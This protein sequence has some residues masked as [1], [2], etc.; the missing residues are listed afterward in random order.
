[1]THKDYATVDENGH[2]ILPPELAAAWGLTPGSRLAVEADGQAVQMRP[3][4]TSLRRVYV[5][6][7]NGCN[8]NCATCMRNVW[9][10]ETGCMSWGTFERILAGIH[11]LQPAPEIFFG[12]YGEPLSH[13]DC[14]EMV[15]RAKALGLQ[16]SLITNGILLTKEVSTRLVDV[17]LDMLWVSLDGASPQSYRDVRLGNA[18]PGI[19]KNLKT[20]RELQ[21][22][23]FE[24]F[25]WAS[26]PRLG[27][28]FVAM[29]RN[30]ADLLNVIRLGKNLGATQFSIS[31]VLAHNEALCEESLYL[32]TIDVPGLL[33]RESWKSQVELPQIDIN[34]ATSD[35]LIELL[36]GDHRLSLF[37]RPINGN[38][39]RCPFVERGSLVVRW[40][41]KVSPCLPLLYTHT[42]YLGE[43]Q[44]TSRE[45]FVGDIHGSD[46]PSI[47][48]EAAYRELRQALDAFNFSPCVTCKGCEMAEDNLEDCFGNTYPT[49]GG[50]LWAQGLIRCP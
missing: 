10:V 47:W 40:D 25:T 16:V 35:I 50:C 28:A 43:R 34:K 6:L 4:I 1:M 21:Y 24:A 27:I 3:P 41:G 42:H 17:G 45:Y 31:N 38:G 12:G 49:C 9:G 14:L 32:R 18:L 7:T 37:G 33:R 48:N 39:D 20:L 15:A 11:S 2:L 44:R 26:H 22:Q 23:R 13:P 30:L 29:R 46:L 8:L 5:E 19:L 36:K